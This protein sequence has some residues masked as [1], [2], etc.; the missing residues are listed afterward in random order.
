M[1]GCWNEANPSD[2]KWNVLSVLPMNDNRSYLDRKR[3]DQSLNPKQEPT[4]D[5]NNLGTNGWN[6]TLDVQ[7]RNPYDC[8]AIAFKLLWITVSTNRMNG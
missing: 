3:R 2:V 4:D 1:N 6:Q 7:H 5:E 8:Y